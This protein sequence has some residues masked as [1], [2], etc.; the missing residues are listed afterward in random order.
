MNG[1]EKHLVSLLSYFWQW[2][3]A[4]GILHKKA[5]SGPT[6]ATWKF[7]STQHTLRRVGK[8]QEIFGYRS[9]YSR[10]LQST[11]NLICIIFVLTASRWC[12]FHHCTSNLGPSKRTFRLSETLDTCSSCNSSKTHR[13][14][15]LGDK[16][17]PGYN[18]YFFSFAKVPKYWLT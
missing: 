4:V 11:S 7:K 18:Y 15:L 14:I 9:T 10:N 16:E 12:Q 1:C 6:S 5:N 8:N 3:K 13:Q 2:L 17:E